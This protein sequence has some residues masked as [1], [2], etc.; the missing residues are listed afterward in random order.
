MSMADILS[1]V[2]RIDGVSGYILLNSKGEVLVHDDEMKSPDKLSKMVYSC[3][4]TL[5][6]LGKN[7]LKYASFTRKQNKN[8]LLFP[9]GNYYLGVLKQPGIRNSET[10]GAVIKFLN[11][12]AGQ[13][14]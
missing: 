11:V 14:K 8:I 10:A 7:Y 3:G 12:L 5:L 2:R 1:H 6:L 9:V 13:R 4:R